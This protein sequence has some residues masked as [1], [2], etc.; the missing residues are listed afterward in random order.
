MT[1]LVRAGY[2]SWTQGGFFGIGL[3]LK[4]ICNGLEIL[5]GGIFV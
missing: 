1:F 4:A 3:L 2:S 5:V